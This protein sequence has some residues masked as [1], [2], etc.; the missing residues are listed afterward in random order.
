MSGNLLRRGNGSHQGLISP[1]AS[2]PVVP[3]AAVEFG[4]VLY[5]VLAICASVH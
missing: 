1:L 2:N 5:Y 3:S 4:T